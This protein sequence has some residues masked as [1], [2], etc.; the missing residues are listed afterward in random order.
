CRGACRVSIRAWVAAPSIA[1]MI[2]ALYL[3]RVAIV[4]M[5][6]ITERSDTLL[7]NS[8]GAHHRS[9]KRSTGQ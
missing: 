4:R 7:R 3:I 9:F 5:S 2:A 8:N 6:L 1:S